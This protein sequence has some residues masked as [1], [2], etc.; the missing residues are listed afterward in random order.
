MCLLNASAAHLPPK[1]Q[2]FP[3]HSSPQPAVGEIP[4]SWTHM[5][6]LPGSQTVREHKTAFTHWQLHCPGGPLHSDMRAGE[7]PPNEP[8]RHSGWT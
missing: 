8:A 7:G 3:D 2:V 4:T 5:P 6:T 1:M